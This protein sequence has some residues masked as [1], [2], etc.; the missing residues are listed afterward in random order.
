MT[1]Q[2]RKVRRWWKSLGRMT[3][4]GIMALATGG[5]ALAV[6]VGLTIGTAS[7]ANP[8]IVCSSIHAN[9]SGTTTG[10]T[11]NTGV[12]IVTAGTMPS[13]GNDITSTTAFATTFTVSE[14]SG[15]V[16]TGIVV[17]SAEVTTTGAG[18]S[19]TDTTTGNPFTATSANDGV[20]TGSIALA[21]SGAPFAGPGVTAETQ[22]GTV[23]TSLAFAALSQQVTT[24]EA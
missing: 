22:V 18:Q 4:L 7:A 20:F 15:S 16:P 2:I 17:L 8:G 24:Q 23:A 11:T 21:T 10:T 1:E 19:F 5:A 9:N 6:I 12:L 3:L 14:V 13:I